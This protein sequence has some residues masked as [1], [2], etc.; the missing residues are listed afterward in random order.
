MSTTDMNS[1]TAAQVPETGTVDF[2]FEVAILAVSDADRAKQFYASLGW[3]EDADFVFTD[4]F[5]VLQ[6]TPPGSQAS[7]IFGTGVTA[8]AP[9]SGASR[10]LAVDDIEAARADL[11]ERGVDVSEIFHGQG[12]SADGQGR[13]P[14]PDPERR[15]YFSY[16]S[17]SD[18][19]GNEWLLQEV[20]TRLP[21][22]VEQRGVA[23]LAE[24]LLET[25]LNHDR[26]EKAAPEHNWWDWYAPYLDARE[27]GST[28]EEAT[29]AADR[30]MEEAHGVVV[31]R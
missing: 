14:G 25:A 19:D 17:F 12:F 26:F 9:G 21:G 30:Y 11:L 31:S 27:H 6:F 28:S 20:T 1:E 23:K 8:A 3:R 2:K 29:A 16:V 4:D 24:L 13:E 22:R 10:L 5:R 7:I 15:S 18:P